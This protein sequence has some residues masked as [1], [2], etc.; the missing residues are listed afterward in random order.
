MK[1]QNKF[2]YKLKDRLGVLVVVPLG[3]SDFS[4]DY[5]R[6]NDE[7]L[8]YK[9]KLSGKITFVGEAF[10]RLMQMESSIYRC[11]EQIL[12]IYKLC[13]GVEKQIFEGRISLNEG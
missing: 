7:K 13:E 8:S 11:D 4:L 12:S 6:E 2:I 1:I 3:E 9:K 5:E 10:K